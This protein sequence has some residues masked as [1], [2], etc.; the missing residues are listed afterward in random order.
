M[1]VKT[2]INLSNKV[3]VR[4]QIAILRAL[5]YTV[6]SRTSPALEEYFLVG[7]GGNLMNLTFEQALLLASFIVAVLQFILT[8]VNRRK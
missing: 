6:M 7:K 4:Q 5:A 1:I 3:D 2:D 8:F